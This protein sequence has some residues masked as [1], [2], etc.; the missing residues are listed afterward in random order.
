MDSNFDYNLQREKE[1]K[2]LQKKTLDEFLQFIEKNKPTKEQIE[3]NKKYSRLAEERY[4]ASKEA[5]EIWLK[6]MQ[7]H[8]MKK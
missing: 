1:E 7:P 8:E 2:E 6:S 5:Q 3:Q 4:I